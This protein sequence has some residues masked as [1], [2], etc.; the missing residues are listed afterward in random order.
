M[1]VGCVSASS[2]LDVLTY[3]NQFVSKS[4]D[5]FAILTEFK[6]NDEPS[7]TVLVDVTAAMAEVPQNRRSIRTSGRGT[8]LGYEP[9]LFLQLNGIWIGWRVVRPC[10]RLHITFVRPIL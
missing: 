8:H 6:I 4:R 1:A 9:W 3:T 10:A 2:S 7:D 5:M